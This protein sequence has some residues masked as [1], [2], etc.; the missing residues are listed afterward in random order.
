MSKRVLC[1]KGWR[2][3]ENCGEIFNT[4]LDNLSGNGP[5]PNHHTQKPLWVTLFCDLDQQLLG[6]W[7]NYISL[8]NPLHA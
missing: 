1:A 6:K 7:H 8:T 4:S 5:T 2:V 3:L